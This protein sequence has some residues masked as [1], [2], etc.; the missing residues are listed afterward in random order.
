MIFSSAL[1]S[2]KVTSTTTTCRSTTTTS[3]NSGRSSNN[4]NN[5]EID[6]LLF[7]NVD[8]ESIDYNST[9]SKSSTEAGVIVERSFSSSDA[10]DDVDI[11]ITSAAEANSAGSSASDLEGHH[12]HRHQG[13]LDEKEEDLLT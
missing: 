4:N 11:F 9:P 12:L 6:R 3:S 8:D 13:L 5:F 1:C 7:T 2:L 10:Y